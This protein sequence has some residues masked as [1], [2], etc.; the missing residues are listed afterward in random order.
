MKRAASIAAA[1]NARKKAK[2]VSMTEPAARAKVSIADVLASLDPEKDAEILPFVR[3][4]AKLTGVR[5]VPKRLVEHGLARI[6]DGKFS[7]RADAREFF[8]GPYVL[9]KGLLEDGESR[10]AV[11]DALAD[12]AAAEGASASESHFVIY[13]IAALQQRQESIAAGPR[14]PEPEP[15]PLE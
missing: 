14:H 11:L 7:L 6:V 13:R 15:Q 4:A 10:N 8:D 1:T 2:I 12:L 5:E 3:H 9:A